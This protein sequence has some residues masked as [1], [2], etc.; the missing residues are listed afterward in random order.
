MYWLKLFFFWDAN[1][2]G[3]LF[4]LQKNDRQKKQRVIFPASKNDHIYFEDADD[5]RSR[6][7]RLYQRVRQ[8][9]GH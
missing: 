6:V 4:M 5:R 9:L 8:N 3:L 1:E 7:G 2:V